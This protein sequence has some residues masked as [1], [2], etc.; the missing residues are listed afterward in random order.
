MKC[1]NTCTMYALQPPEYYNMTLFGGV[2]KFDDGKWYWINA[3][4]SKI[5]EVIPMFWIVGHPTG[6]EGNTV[7]SFG[8]RT[9]GGMQH[10][11]LI[12]T[13]TSPQGGTFCMYGK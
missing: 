8:H 6:E 2:Q 10:A 9:I 5:R 7:G 13:D 11:G 12:D 3:D 4:G 1:S